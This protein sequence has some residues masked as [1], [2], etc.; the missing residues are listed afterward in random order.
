MVSHAS[1]FLIQS[2]RKRDGRVVSFDKNRIVSA[3]SS[4]MQAS[5]EGDTRRDPLLIADR[6]IKR[7][8]EKY[9]RGGVPSI[10]AIQDVAEESL[11]LLDFPKTAKAYILYRSER[12]H[13]RE[14]KRVIPEHVQAFAQESKK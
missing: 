4:A 8:T 12:A 7:L 14:N 6:V 9:P 3:V 10:E 2:V 13:I 5:G 11:I 1:S